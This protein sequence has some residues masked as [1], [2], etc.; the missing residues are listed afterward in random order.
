MSRGDPP[1]SDGRLASIRALLSS[2]SIAPWL[3][4]PDAAAAAGNATGAPEGSLA[5][6]GGALGPSAGG[7][8]GPGKQSE[9]APRNEDTGA[10]RPRATLGGSGLP[11]PPPL[12]AAHALLTREAYCVSALLE[13]F[14]AEKTLLDTLSL[15]TAHRA[16][17]Y[18]YRCNS[19][20]TTVVAGSASFSVATVC[21]GGPVDMDADS[22]DYRSHGNGFPRPDAAYPPALAGDA[23]GL[24]AAMRAVDALVD[25][26]ATQPLALIDAPSEAQAQIDTH[27]HTSTPAPAA[28]SMDL[29][30]SD[31]LQARYRL[32]ACLAQGRG[33]LSEPYCGLPLPLASAAAGAGAGGVGLSIGEG[34]VNAEWRT[35][36]DDAHPPSAPSVSSPYAD[37]LDDIRLLRRSLGPARRSSS[38]AAAGGGGAGGGSPEKARISSPSFASAASPSAR[39]SGTGAPGSPCAGPT[40]GVGAV[41]HHTVAGTRLVVPAESWEELGESIFYYEFLFIHYSSAFSSLRILMNFLSPDFTLYFFEFSAADFTL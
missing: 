14:R 18:P 11:P 21:A 27:T 8:E 41:C 22:F 20:T 19:Y 31:H 17:P 12:A 35:L 25:L 28:A 16:R 26:Y 4:A 33:L 29:A 40:S 13:T 32:A 30:L 1:G 36:F 2:R 34:L 3:P 15:D 5:Q 39:A 7:D 38:T 37:L 24:H 23:R 6:S 9:E 10:A